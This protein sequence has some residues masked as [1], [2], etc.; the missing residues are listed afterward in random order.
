[1]V[2]EDVLDHPARAI[3]TVLRVKPGPLLKLKLVKGGRL[4]VVVG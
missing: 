3:V 1:M 2:G 4:L